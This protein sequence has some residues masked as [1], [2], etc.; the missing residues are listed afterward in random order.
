M[1]SF[2][3][4]PIVQDDICII[5]NSLR[6]SSPGWHDINSKV[7]KYVSDDILKPLAH[8]INLSL[9]TGIFPDNQTLSKV[10][11]LYKKG[12]LE[13]FI[14]CRPNSNLSFFSKIFETAAYNKLILYLKTHLDLILYNFQFGF[15]KGYNT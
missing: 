5:I 7:V 12:D 6:N 9:Q 13:L 2:Y 15:H 4:R 14:N 1:H 8:I 10:T 11:S 3:F